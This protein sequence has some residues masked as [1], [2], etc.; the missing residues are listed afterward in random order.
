MSI[1]STDPQAPPRIE[2][3]HLATETDRQ[4]FVSLFHWLRGWAGNP[5]SGT[6]SSSRWAGPDLETDADILAVWLRHIIG[7]W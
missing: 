6:G 1:V 3:N 7:T 5:R 4:H 2:G